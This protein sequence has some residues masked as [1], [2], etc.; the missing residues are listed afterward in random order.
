MWEAGEAPGLESRTEVCRSS[1]LGPTLPSCVLE[2]P[3][4]QL[5]ISPCE[6]WE[7]VSRPEE[8]W[9]G[10]FCGPEPLSAL[11][12][13]QGQSCPAPLWDMGRACLM[14]VAA[15]AVSP[16]LHTP[17][18]AQLQLSWGC[19]DPEVH[20][21]AAPLSLGSPA[22]TGRGASIRVASGPCVAGR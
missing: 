10:G 2:E 3:P 11:G 18:P 13:A 6:L 4:P 21:L 1:G 8:H 19:S 20:P 12:T 15:V 16:E 7:P 5:Q 22:G 9:G 14:Q 17:G